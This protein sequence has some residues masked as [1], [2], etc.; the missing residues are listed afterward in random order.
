MLWEQEVPGSN[1]TIPAKRA[2]Y[3]RVLASPDDAQGRP[4]VI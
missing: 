4:A 1:P 3:E 2:A